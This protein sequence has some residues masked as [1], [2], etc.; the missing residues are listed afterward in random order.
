[1]KRYVTNS[2]TWNHPPPPSPP[3][4]FYRIRSIIIV[5]ILFERRHQWHEDATVLRQ[6][7]QHACVCGQRRSGFIDRNEMKCLK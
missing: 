3:P 6:T 2:P 4:E 5:R 7:E 1:M